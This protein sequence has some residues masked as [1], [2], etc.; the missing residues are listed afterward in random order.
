[1]GYTH[2]YVISPLQGFFTVQVEFS[3][4]N[5]LVIVANFCSVNSCL[6]LKL[7]FYWKKIG[8]IGN[9]CQLWQLVACYYQFVEFTLIY[10]IFNHEHD[11]TADDGDREETKTEPGGDDAKH[12][13]DGSCERG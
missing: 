6:Q 8:K 11:K 12:K 5:F 7:K 13:G 1:M 3:G 2:A 9:Y 4:I 10:C